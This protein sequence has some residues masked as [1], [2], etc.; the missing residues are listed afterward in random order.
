MTDIMGEHQE[1]ATPPVNEEVSQ[2]AQ[3]EAKMVPLE[4]LQAERQQRQALDDKLQAIENHMQL[5][6]TQQ[7]QAQTA[8]DEPGLQDDDILTVGEAKK[9]MSEIDTKY[10]ASMQEVKMQQK[11]PDYKDVVTKYLP[12][13]IKE[14]P[15]LADNLRKTQDYELAYE[16]AKNSEGYRQESNKKKR[17]AD[18]DAILNNASESGALSS[19]GHTSPVSQA[20]RYKQMNDSDFK[21]LVSRNMG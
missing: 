6:Q 21:Q 14:K 17:S 8:K 12:E 15:W 1:A 20:K 2:E 3:A 13:I 11:Y 18:A 5:L 16:L 10:Q 9:F 7:N 4:A 19:V